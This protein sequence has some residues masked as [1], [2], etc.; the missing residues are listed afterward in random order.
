MLNNGLKSSPIVSC[1]WLHKNLHLENLVLLDASV[2][3]NVPESLSE[4]IPS[5]IPLD[6]KGKFSDVSGKFPNT[7][8]SLEQ[9]QH[10]AQ[11]L[12][13]NNNSLVVVY[14]DKGLYWSPRVWWLFKIFGFSNVYVLDGGLP[15]W[16][17]RGFKVV[18]SSDTRAHLVSDLSVKYDNDKM[19][20]Y[21]DIKE[22]TDNPNVLILDARSQDRFECKVPEPRDGLR[23]GTIRNSK[24]LPFTQL[25]DGN[26][27]KPKA[28]LKTIFDTFESNDKSLVFSCGSGITACIL[29]LAAEIAGYEKL[30]VYDG[31]WTEYGTLTK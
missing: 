9:F 30:S 13:I 15:E 23:S 10:E 8:P 2:K 7:M 5:S 22:L 31:S 6:I 27:L 4:Y 3:S 17:A 12:G 29:A 16:K 24:N 28:E 25:L 19:C 21:K 11:K 18:S 26:C 1:N 14:D 20:F